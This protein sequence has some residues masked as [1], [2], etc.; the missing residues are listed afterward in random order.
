VWIIAVPRSPIKSP[1]SQPV[2]LKSNPSELTGVMSLGSIASK[3]D[4]LIADHASLSI[5]GLGVNT[6]QL[7]VVLG[8]DDKERAGLT[9]RMQT[10]EV[11]VA[12]IHDVKGA[13][14][15]W[16]EVQYVDFVHLPVADV[17]KGWDIAPQIEQRVK[18][19]CALGT[20]KVSPVEQAQTQIDGRGI[21]C[22][23]GVV[24][25]QAQ[26]DVAIELSG[27]FDQHCSHIG[28]NAPVSRFVRVGQ[29]RTLHRMPETQAVTLARMSCQR[30]DQVAQ[31][32][33]GC[34][35]SKGHGAKLLRTA[36]SSDASV[37]AVA[38]D[39][40]SHT[41]PRHKLHE[42]GKDRLANVHEQL[43]KLL[44]FRRYS[45]MRIQRSNRHQKK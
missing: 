40:S 24:D 22:V 33:P 5:V 1:T 44:N 27:L 3:D 13:G 38:I 26:F 36:Q 29:C 20:T 18:F 12:T 43:Q 10:L 21:Q 16:Q 25:V 45:K 35:L 39:D 11:E 31:T 34:Q 28:P 6:P 15:G 37:A 41:G 14:L 32:L 17:N 30:G 42:L 8:P 4:R 2:D 19:D 9:Q 23:D 7:R